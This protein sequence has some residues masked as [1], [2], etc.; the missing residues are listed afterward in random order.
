MPRL[1]P[2]PL[3]LNETDR[4]QLQQGLKRHS[5]PHHIALRAN[6]IL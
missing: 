1:A 3:Q 4:T 2:P 5:T 6:I